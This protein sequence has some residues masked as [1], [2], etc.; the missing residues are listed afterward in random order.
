M[1][2]LVSPALPAGISSPAPQGV[3]GS[4]AQHAG[5]APSAQTASDGHAVAPADDVVEFV[6]RDGSRTRCSLWWRTTPVRQGRRTG[7]IGALAS[8][9]SSAVTGDDDRSIAALLMLACERLREAGCEL[10][11]GPVDGDTWHRYR[12]VTW[13]DGT[14][15]FALEP[16]SAPDAV[17]PW[18]RAGFAPLETYASLRDD[19]LAERDPR[20]VALTERFCAA[21]VTLRDLDHARFNEELAAVHALALRGFRGAPLYVPIAFEAFAALYRPLAARLDPR[22]C[23]VAEHDG[24]VAGVLFA[25][26]DPNAPE[27]VVLKT[28]VRDTDRRFAG[29]GAVLTDRA[30]AAAHA[31]GATRAISALQHDGDVARS[32]CP[33]AVVFRRYAVFAKELS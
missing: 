15:P 21:G 27:T 32:L 9:D 18:E 11:V 31:L 17:V 20:A 13:S 33:R 29:L 24:R 25:L 30:R 14:P 28:I 3:Q 19:A 7:F 2:V 1:T 23:P 10:A 6:G 16:W 5:V 8:N 12:L 22:L 26:R 4:S